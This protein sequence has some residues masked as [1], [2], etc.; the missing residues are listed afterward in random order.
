MMRASSWA[1]DVEQNIPNVSPATAQEDRNQWMGDRRAPSSWA[2]RLNKEVSG[3]ANLAGSHGPFHR[4]GRTTDRHTPSRG[5]TAEHQCKQDRVNK[6]H[7]WFG[8]S[9]SEESGD[10]DTDDDWSRVDREGRN[11]VRRKRS[12]DKLHKKMAEISLK[13]RQMAGIGPINENDINVHMRKNRN[14]SQAKI[15]AVKTHL[16]N[17]Y[18]YNQEELENIEILETKRNVKDNI[19]YIA[20]SNERDVKDIYSRKAEVRSDNT[21]VKS[22]IPPQYFERFSALN[23]ICAARREQNDNLKT[24]IRFGERDLI[25][26]TKEKG[27]QEPYRIENLYSFVDGEDLPAIDMSIKWKFQEDRPPRRRVATPSPDP[28]SRQQNEDLVMN[29]NVSTTRQLSQSS[30]EDAFA[31]KRRKLANQKP[32]FPAVEKNAMDITL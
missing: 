22:F 16:K 28:A 31:N 6:I 23:R 4:D 18:R 25:V 15:Q 3:A 24:Q 1:D 8:T 5:K 20:V 9:S 27:S 17:H 21:I 11:L 19:V 29:S 2:D 32:G 7:H 14:Y 30:Q 12:Q 26:L 13:A 10:D